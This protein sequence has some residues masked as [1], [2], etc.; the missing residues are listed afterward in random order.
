[1]AV[2]LV[3]SQSTARGFY[4]RSGW[5]EVGTAVQ[6]W[7]HRTVAAVLMVP[8]DPPVRSSDAFG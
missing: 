7:G 6:R 3:D 1:M 4:R 2:L 5:Q 8:N